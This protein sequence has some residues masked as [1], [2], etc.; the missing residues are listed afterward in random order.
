MTKRR[1]GKRVKDPKGTS[2]ARTKPG[3]NGGT[4][5]NPALPPNASVQRRR[6]SP[7]TTAITITGVDNEFSY[8]SALKKAREVIPLSELGIDRSRVRRTIKEGRIIEIPG[9][10][11][12]SKADILAEKLRAVLGLSL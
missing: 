12:A 7:R 3:Y 4:A 11:A 6:R 2:L 1:R 10:D 9:I 8:V 5:S